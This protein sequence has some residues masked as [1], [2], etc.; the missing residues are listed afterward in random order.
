MI[1]PNMS[2]WTSPPTAMTVPIEMP[3]TESVSSV[4]GDSTPSK[5]LENKEVAV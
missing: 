2:S 3:T 1:N 5:Y 4:L